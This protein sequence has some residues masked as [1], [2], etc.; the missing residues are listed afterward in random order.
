MKSKHKG[1]K[2]SAVSGEVQLKFAI[3]D[4][5][6]PSANSQQILRKFFHIAA[7]SPGGEEEDEDEEELARLES[8]ETDVNEDKDEDTSDETDDPSKPEVT[9]KRKKK[10]RLKRLKKKTKARA[11][12]FTA[13]SDWV[14]IVFIEVGKITDLPPERNSMRSLLRFY[15][16]M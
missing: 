16:M 7:V 4:P 8:A 10:L 1:P 13:G 2:K 14:G 12:E 5:A 3:L 11:Y 15:G 9:E 6:D